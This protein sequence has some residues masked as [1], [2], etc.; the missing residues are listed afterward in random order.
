MG[1]CGD[2]MNIKES[3][4]ISGGRAKSVNT[5]D[6]KKKVQYSNKIKALNISDI[7]I[8][9][10]DGNFFAIEKLKTLNAQNCDIN[11]MINDE[12]FFC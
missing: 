2:C 7:K 12:K 5:S 10:F 9:V 1:C 8:Q 11:K 4:T 3:S 6:L